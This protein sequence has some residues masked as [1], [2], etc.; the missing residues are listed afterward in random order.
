MGRL[1]QQTLEFT[2]RAE[3]FFTPELSLQ[4]YGSPYYSAGHYAK[5]YFVNVG[6]ANSHNNEE[7]F[8]QVPENNVLYNDESGT[9]SLI[10][11]GSRV[12][13]PI[14]NPDF[15]FGQFRSN[16]VFRW[17]YKPASVLYLVWS[18]NKTFDENIPVP[19][20]SDSISNLSKV[21]GKNIFLIKLNYWF[22]I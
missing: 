7:R 5:F 14:D 17:E 15:C 16:L 13:Y 10:E 19:D 22:S 6:Q 18:H 4:F 12:T 11:S 21:K 8:T 2:V 1:E 20:L 3:L 9:V